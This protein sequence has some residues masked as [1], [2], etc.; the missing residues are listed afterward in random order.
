M[1]VHVG[2]T[3]CR[4]SLAKPFC[5]EHPIHFRAVAFRRRNTFQKVLNH[6][7]EELRSDQPNPGAELLDQYFTHPV[8]NGSTEF[9]W[10]YTP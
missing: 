6:L 1:D 10:W 2:I 7:V 5:S 8:L 4:F 9:A 3:D